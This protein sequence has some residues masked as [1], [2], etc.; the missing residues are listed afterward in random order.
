[1]EVAMA[2]STSTIDPR[3]GTVTSAGSIRS[4]EVPTAVAPELVRSFWGQPSL[5]TSLVTMSDR[6]RASE[7]Q[8]PLA[9]DLITTVFSG[10]LGRGDSANGTCMVTQGFLSQPDGS[11]GSLGPLREA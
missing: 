9:R 10:A 11:G 4:V 2:V 7:I 3:E 1:M 5:S 6:Q 8:A